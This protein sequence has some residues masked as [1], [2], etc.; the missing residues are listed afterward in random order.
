MQGSDWVRLWEQGRM[1]LLGSGGGGRV[2]VR[3]MTDLLGVSKSLMRPPFR[4]CRWEKGLTRIGVVWDRTGDGESRTADL[5][6]QRPG[7][8]AMSRE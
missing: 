4:S 1:G 7:S 6:R 3:E 2:K 5:L 8:D